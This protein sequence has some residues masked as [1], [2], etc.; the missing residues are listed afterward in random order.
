[1]FAIVINWQTSIAIDDASRA[2]AASTRI[3]IRCDLDHC[4]VDL[5]G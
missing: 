4:A 3:E 2:I 5:V 1:M